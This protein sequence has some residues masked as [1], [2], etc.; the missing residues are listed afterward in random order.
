ME[1]SYVTAALVAT[2]FFHNLGASFGRTMAVLRGLECTCGNRSNKSRLAALACL[3]AFFWNAVCY[4]FAYAAAL[5][6]VL[7]IS[8]QKNLI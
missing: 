1:R 2:F 8:E 7:T 3:R 6:D 5:S 4:M